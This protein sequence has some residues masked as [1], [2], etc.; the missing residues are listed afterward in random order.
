MNSVTNC[1][2]GAESVIERKTVARYYGST[3]IFKYKCPKCV[4]KELP[5]LRQGEN[6][7][8]LQEWN[9]IAKKSPYHKRTLEYNDSGICVSPPFKTFEWRNTKKYED[10]VVDFYFDNSMYYYRYGYNYKNSGYSFGL[11]ISAPGFP[12]LETAKKNAMEEIIE[13]KKDLEKI[14]RILLV[15]VQGNLFD[16]EEL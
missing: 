15:S 1:L 14:A 9:E 11:D 3:E 12:S 2:C 13:N 16:Q 10:V 6:H 5:W 7:G 4:E 8:A